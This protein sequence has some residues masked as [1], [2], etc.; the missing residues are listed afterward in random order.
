[1]VATSCPRPKLPEY[2]TV[3]R[4]PIPHSRRYAFSRRGMAGNSSWSLQTLMSR[5]AGLGDPLGHHAV[6]HAAPQDHG[7]IRAAQAEAVHAL[8]EAASRAIPAS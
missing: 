3:K 1:M 8:E 2:M 7:A 4:S 5:Q 6:A